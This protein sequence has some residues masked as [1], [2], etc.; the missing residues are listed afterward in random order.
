MLTESVKKALRIS[1]NDFDDDIND[2]IR[3][4][5]ADMQ[6]SGITVLTDNNPLVAQAIKLYCKAH[7]GD[8]DSNNKFL[9]AYQALKISMSLAGEF[10]ERS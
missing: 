9:N 8:N 7:F 3:A 5:K 2:L 1:S 4:A 10:R 6:M